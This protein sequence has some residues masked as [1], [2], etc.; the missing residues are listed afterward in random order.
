MSVV[1]CREKAILIEMQVFWRS[2]K[3]CASITAL[4]SIADL[5]DAAKRDSTQIKFKENQA[6]YD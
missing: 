4:R 2:S 6:F 5:Q 1:G 3:A